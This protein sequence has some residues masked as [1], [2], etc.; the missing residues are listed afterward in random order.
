[1][2]TPHP[3]KIVDPAVTYEILRDDS[4]WNLL[5]LLEGDLERIVKVLVPDG[6]FIR[7]TYSHSNTVYLLTL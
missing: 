3:P 6:E 7:S 2:W 1:V 4:E 5:G